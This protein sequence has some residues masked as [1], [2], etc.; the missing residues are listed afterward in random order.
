MDEN[1]RC[2]IG[3]RALALLPPQAL[4]VN[5]ARAEVVDEQALY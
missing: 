4:L 2:L 5:V 3:A 1:T